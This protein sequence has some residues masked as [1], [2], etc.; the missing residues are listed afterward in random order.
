MCKNAN[1]FKSEKEIVPRGVV[2]L[3]FI[4]ATRRDETHGLKSAMQRS[5]LFEFILR[6]ATVWVERVYSPEEK[7]SPYLQV[8]I[9]LYIKPFYNGSIIIE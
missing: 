5:E 7:V 3:A 4:G 1:N 9:I 2:E 8:Y 6:I